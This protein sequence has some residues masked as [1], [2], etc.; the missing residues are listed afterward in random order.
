MNKFYSGFA[1]AYFLVATIFLMVIAVLLLG[2]AMW[3]ILTQYNSPDLVD[4]AL[5]GIGLTII[6]FAVVE[7]GKFI[8]EEEILRSRQLR[9]SMESR[10]SLTKFTTIIVIAM[11]LEALVMVFKTNNE[12][13]ENAVYPAILFAAAMFS[14]I[15]LGV[16]QYLSSRI[17]PPSRDEKIE[18]EKNDEDN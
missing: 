13:V 10:R 18:A 15:A 3:E 11:S 12:G 16:Y 2:T 8:A 7:T 9:S 5:N 4:V 14:L 6:G 1:Y 17:Q